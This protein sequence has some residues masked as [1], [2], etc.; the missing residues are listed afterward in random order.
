MS[1]L[2]NNI[3]EVVSFKKFSGSGF[4]TLKCPMCNDNKIRAGFKFDS[5]RIIYQCFRGKCDATTVYEYGKYMNRKFKDLMKTLN[6]NVPIDLLTNNIKAKKELTS[7]DKKLYNKITYH[8]IKLKPQ[9]E[10]VSS[11]KFRSILQE[12]QVTVDRELYVGT[13]GMW[14]YRLIIPFYH[15]NKLIGWQ[16]YNQRSNTPYLTSSGNEHLLFINTD[17]GIIP[18]QPI[19]VEGAFDAWCIP[20]G[21]ATLDNTVSKEQAYLL[22]NTNP[23]LVPDR[24][25]S[26]YIKIAKKYGWRISIPDWKEKDVNAAVQHYGKLIVAKMIHDGIEKNTLKA[27]AKYKIWKIW[28]I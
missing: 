23:I 16:G 10:P 12:R 24:K 4:N 28:K 1:E 14:K 13:E 17:G 26:D 7:I 20:N 19:I 2:E 5:D 21:I 11:K 15:N 3:R 6:V 22:R 25:D 18:K 9:F 8:E 27:E